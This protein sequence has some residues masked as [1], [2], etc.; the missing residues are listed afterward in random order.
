MYNTYGITPNTLNYKTYKD[1]SYDLKKNLY[2]I[3]SNI[4]LI[5]GIPRSGIVP[6]YML[7]L[8][9]SKQACSI[10]EFISGDFKSVATYRVNLNKEVKNVL[11]I[12]DSINTGRASLDTKKLIKDSGLE[13]RYNIFYAAVYYKDDNYKQFI[14]IAFEKVPQPRVFQWNYL[15]HAFLKDAAFDIDG[16]LCVDPTNEE[17]DDGEN[18]KHFLLNAQPL[19]IP[20][21]K[22]PYIITSRLEKYRQETEEWLHKNNVQYDHLIMLSGY[23]AEE[24]KKM[25]MHGKFKAEQYNKLFDIQLFIESNRKQAEEIANLSNKLCFCTATD[26]LFGRK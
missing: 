1:L 17:N 8:M 10:R 2:K 3:P 6:A 14:D 7:A 4:D 16:V 23:T 11:I 5:V 20:K 13:Q 25:N 22:I 26:E 12:D 19:F 18:Y 21:H 24:R 9:L 15:N